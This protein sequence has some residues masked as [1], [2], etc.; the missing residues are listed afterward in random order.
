[1]PHNRMNYSCDE[2]G[3]EIVIDTIVDSDLWKEISPTGDAGGLLCAS[4]MVERI[5]KVR[6]GRAW[7]AI[8]LISAHV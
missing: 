6:T 8:R 2:C 4:C 3:R 7:A 1:M 5:A